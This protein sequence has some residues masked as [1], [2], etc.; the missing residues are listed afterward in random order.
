MLYIFDLDGT[1]AESFTGSTLLPN[2][3]EMLQKIVANGDQIAIASNQGGVACRQ[4]WGFENF[5]TLDDVRTRFQKIV[6]EI[7]DVTGL[8]NIPVAIAYA[9]FH[10]NSDSWLYADFDP[11]VEFSESNNPDW[12]KPNFG[13]IDYLNVYGV[14][15]TYVG[16][17][18]SDRHAAENAGVIYYDAE[19]FFSSI[20]ILR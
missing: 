16:D 18:E 3:A 20:V 6:N 5:P 4:A 2:R 7:K 15:A 13:M 9:Y 19:E 1:L 10:K 14:T 12:R 8:E 11:C 17:M